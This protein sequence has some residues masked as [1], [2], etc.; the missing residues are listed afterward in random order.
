MPNTPNVS[1]GRT[2]SGSNASSVSLNDIKSLIESSKTE[3][4]SVVKNESDRLKAMIKSFNSRLDEVE[5]KNNLLESRCK[6]LEE[7]CTKY[8]KMCQQKET[9]DQELIDEA[10]ER[11]RRRKYL[12]ITGLPEPKKGGVDERSTEDRLTVK[13][14]ASTLGVDD[15]DPEEVAR[16]GR[17]SRDRPR[18]LRFK[19]CSVDEKL[20]LLRAAKDLRKHA[21]YRGVY[22]NPDSTRLQR[23]KNKELRDELK[24]R[25]EAGEE[26]IIYRGRIIDKSERPNAN[27]H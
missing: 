6:T 7:K 12:I 21:A 11:Q 4:L 23:V 9:S 13:E 26:V 8:E 17:I 25:R 24:R 16:I 14:L 10:M 5:R 19:C 15:L 1:Q 22:I 27:F 2:R 20:S 18:L 3:I